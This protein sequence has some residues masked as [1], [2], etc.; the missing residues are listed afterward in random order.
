MK[1]RLAVVRRECQ[2]SRYMVPRRTIC[3]V[4]PKPQQVDTHFAWRLKDDSLFPNAMMR[5][6]HMV[7]VTENT[8]N[9][10]RDQMI[11]HIRDANVVARDAIVHGHHPFGAVL[12]GPDN[13]VLMRQA[14]IN[15]VRHAETEIARRA[16]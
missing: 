7:S 5:G 4:N 14:N 13:H 2:P 9:M 1:M 8:D 3:K 11:A 15:T 10:T 12:I 6:Q 16:A